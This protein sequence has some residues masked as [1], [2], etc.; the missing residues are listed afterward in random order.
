MRLS[1][2]RPR[3]VYKSISMLS[4]A[5]SLVGISGT[6]TYRFNQKKGL[7]R[8]QPRSLLSPQSYDRPSLWAH[9]I[10]INLTT[11]YRW[12]I[13]PESYSYSKVSDNL[14][15]PATYDK[16][17]RRDNKSL[18]L[19]VIILKTDMVAASASLLYYY[20]IE[21][22]ILRPLGVTASGSINEISQFILA[23]ASG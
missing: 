15:A 3:R 7:I 18:A 5:I 8:A 12:I 4:R 23:C 20:A 22:C 21:E 13:L 6:R 11:H 2:R 10:L 1:A 9:I 16:E 19:I 14:Q 17:N